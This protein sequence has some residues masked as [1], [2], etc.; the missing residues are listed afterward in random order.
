MFGELFA[1]NKPVSVCIMHKLIYVITDTP[2]FTD[3]IEKINRRCSVDFCT[4]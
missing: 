1:F 2:Y 3:K 4:V